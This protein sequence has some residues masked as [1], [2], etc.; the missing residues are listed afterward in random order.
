LVNAILA[1]HPAS[2]EARAWKKKIRAAQQAEA[3]MK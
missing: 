3:G 2:A 1:G